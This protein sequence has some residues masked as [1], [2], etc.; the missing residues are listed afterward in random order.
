MIKKSYKVKGLDDA[1][2]LMTSAEA[3]V[4]LRVKLCT[5]R[6][7]SC[8]GVGPVAHKI[9]RRKIC[10]YMDDLLAFVQ[11]GKLPRKGGNAI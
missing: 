5:L 8:R 4:Y 3:A 11:A 10:F 2:Q 1:Q 9:G 6:K 7:W